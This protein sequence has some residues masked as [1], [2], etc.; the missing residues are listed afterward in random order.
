MTRS[1]HH[2]AFTRF[3]INGMLPDRTF[4]TNSS[5]YSSSLWLGLNTVLSRGIGLLKYDLFTC[6]DTDFFTP[7]PNW[8]DDIPSAP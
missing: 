1:L 5:Y 8:M 3:C 7:S 2:L 4:L 6:F